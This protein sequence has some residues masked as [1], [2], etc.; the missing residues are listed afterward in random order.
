M[1]IVVGWGG[2]GEYLEHGCGGSQNEKMCVDIEIA[3]K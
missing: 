3:K 2:E 1:T